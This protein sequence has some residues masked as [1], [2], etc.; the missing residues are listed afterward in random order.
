MAAGNSVKHIALRLES[1]AE[2]R[3]EE[4]CLRR[5]GGPKKNRERQGAG[6]APAASRKIQDLGVSQEAV[7][8]AN[9]AGAHARR[10]DGHCRRGKRNHQQQDQQ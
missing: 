9:A 7:T 2:W 10:S 6:A 1:N 8:L 4:S 3:R 5:K